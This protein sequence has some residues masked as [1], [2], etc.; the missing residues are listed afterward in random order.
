[1]QIM[2][3]YKRK[4]MR[5]IF[6]IVLIISAIYSCDFF[7][8]YDLEFVNISEEELDFGLFENEKQF[9]IT[10]A[11]SFDVSWEIV[12]PADW[13]SI[14]PLSGIIN[15]ND[16]DTI[17]VKLNRSNLSIGK[18]NGKI[19]I[20]FQDKTNTKPVAVSME[21]KALHKISSDS[22]RFSS[23]DTLNSFILSNIGNFPLKWDF[24]SIDDWI[25]ADPDTGTLAVDSSNYLSKSITANSVNQS[26]DT[27]ITIKINH[28]ILAAGNHIGILQLKTNT[29]TDTIKLFVTKSAEPL[30]SI[31]IDKLDFGKDEISKTIEIE[32]LGGAELTWTAESKASWITVSPMSGNAEI[33]TN[34]ISKKGNSISGTDKVNSTQ[35]EIVVNRD[36]LTPGSYSSSIDINSNGGNKSIEVTMTV[37]EVPLLK[38]SET[39]I[40]FGNTEIMK[41]VQISNT[42]TGKLI[43]NVSASEPWITVSPMNDSTSTGNKEIII[44]VVRLGLMPGNYSGNV[45]ISSNG[46]SK[47]LTVNMSIDEFPELSVNTTALLFGSDKTSLS[48]NINNIG[49]GEL[50]WQLTSNES[51]LL[52][53]PSSGKTTTEDEEINVTVNRIG[54][55]AGDYTGSINIGTNAGNGSVSVSMSVVE[56]PL[57]SYSPSSINFGDKD[58]TAAF[59]IKNVGEGNLNWQISTDESWIEL[60]KSN[61]TEVANQESEIEIKINKSGLQPGDYSGNINI[62]SNGGSGTIEVSLKINKTP[63]LSYSP[64]SL[65]FGDKDSSKTFEIKNTGTGSLN[66]ELSTDESWISLSGTNGVTNGNEKSEIEVTVNRNNLPAGE[67]SGSVKIT[68]DAGE[69]TVDVSMKVED[70][71]KIAISE[72]NLDFNTDLNSL[73]FRISNKGTGTL[74]W[75]IEGTVDNWISINPGSGS[76]TTG[77]TDVVV[78]INRSLLSPGNYNTKIDISSNGGKESI[79][80]KAEV[81]EVPVLSVIPAEIDF[82]SV[83]NSS[84]ILI[85]NIGTGKLS[86]SSEIM[87]IDGDEGWLRMNP[88][89]GNTSSTRSINLSVDRNGLSLGTHTADIQIYSDGGNKTVHLYLSVAEPVLEVSTDLLDFGSDLTELTFEISNTGG[90]ELEWEITTGTFDT[91]FTVEPVSGTT[92]TEQNKITVTVG[93]DPGVLSQYAGLNKKS[94][95]NGIGTT[96]HIYVTSGEVTKSINV[97]ITFGTGE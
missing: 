34:K 64:Q 25:I 44:S 92:T 79:N 3:G 83:L 20:S 72:N 75:N 70:K 38:V 94:S 54:L 40:N 93:R 29:G 35:I 21:I 43:W 1:M 77:E 11:D 63:K 45:E 49:G 19:E 60:S 36:G 87:Y 65:N 88:T 2:L 42:G 80:I 24:T 6:S 69:G 14:S 47:T 28:N 90:G 51:W 48:F 59:K 76:L 73:S 86:W 39:V 58:S 12:P 71:P 81:L 10:Y 8:P 41:R 53:E 84:S 85:Q 62:S 50:E 95:A 26:T 13:I 18:Y 33:H 32:N 96:G 82:G 97:F 67:Y 74:T 66:W 5:K 68:S 37:P 9:I 46:G 56:I 55:A 78:N 4:L 23:A 7:A 91:W 16:P 52:F 22:L 89:S 17:T 30:L 27:T 15:V 31:N 61:G 57:L